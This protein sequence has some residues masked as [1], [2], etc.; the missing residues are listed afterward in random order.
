MELIVEIGPNRGSVYKIS[1]KRTSIGRVPTNTIVFNDDKISRNHCVIEERDG[2]FFAKDLG[3][4]NGTFVNNVKISDTEL[5]HGDMI[6]VGSCVFRVDMTPSKI[7]EIERNAGISGAVLTTIGTAAPL[8]IKEDINKTIS[9]NATIIRFNQQKAISDTQDAQALRRA[10]KN[11]NTIYEVN[12]AI[13]SMFNLQELFNKIMDTIFSVIKADRGFI[14]LINE[15]SGDW[16]VPVIKKR[17]EN[18]KDETP[19]LSKSIVNRVLQNSESVLTSDAASDER[20]ASGQ[21]IISFG[22][23]SLMCVPL[24]SK[25]KIIGVINV[26]T[27]GTKGSFTKDE[28]ELLSAIGNV[29]GVAVQNA[30]LVESNI[31][32]TR[33]TAI[34][35]TVACLSH[36]IKNILL[37][38]DAGAMVVDMGLKKN[39]SSKVEHG[40]TAV[41]RCKD[42]IADLVL[43]MLNLSKDREPSLDEVNVKDFIDDVIVTCQ[44]RADEKKIKLKSV[45]ADNIPAIFF[46]KK[47]MDRVISNLVSNSVDAVE[48]DNGEITISAEFDT[49]ADSLILKVTDNGSGIPADKITKIFDMD[50]STKGSK[51]TG[52][53]LA[54]VKKVITEHKGT[55]DVSSVAGKGTTFRIILHRFPKTTSEAKK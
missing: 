21:S 22:I 42:K 4:T 31:K 7:A 49:G 5:H 36:D 14:M 32:A 39:D 9:S 30:R 55:I 43:D 10:I 45:C 41:K 3:S 1:Q 25:E 26:D 47:S 17:T 46:D 33:M 54:V 15:Q 12:N 6:T 51:G 29:A 53:G 2:R 20:F 19:T 52:I 24:K 23:T 27:K 34:G 13:S 35:Q 48:K 28:L 38:L 50:F 16:E 44:A 40:W 18:G 8:K 11:L 37:G